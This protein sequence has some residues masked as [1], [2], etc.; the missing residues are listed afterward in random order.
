VPLCRLYVDLMKLMAHYECNYHIIIKG[1]V[2]P[3]ILTT[4]ANGTLHERD[5]RSLII[6]TTH[7]HA[8]AHTHT[9]VRGWMG[10]CNKNI[11]SKN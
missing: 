10:A 9:L 1:P 6:Q 4:T 7:T 5:I 2:S 11:N 8:H 3:T